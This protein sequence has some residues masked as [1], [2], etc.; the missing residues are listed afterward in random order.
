M[1]LSFRLIRLEL[2]HTWTI[3]RASVDFHDNIFVYLEHDGIAGIGEASFSRRYGESLESLQT[4][5]ESAKPVLANADPSHFAEIGEALQKLHPQQNSAKAALDMALMDWVGKKI[6]VPLFR[7]W[8]LN[9]VRTPVSS[10]TIGIDTPEMVQHKIREAQ[11][12][13][14]LKIKLGTARD[15]EIMRAVREATDKPLRIDAN[16]GWKSKE[17]ALEKICWLSQFNIEFVEQPMP[18]G[19]HEEMRWLRQ[20]L[21]QRRVP[22]P[23][24]A[25]EDSKTPR[26]LPALADVYD[27]INIK[28]M[29][30]G[31]LQQALRM[32]CL[33]RS[34]GLKIMLGCM[35]ESSVGITAAAHLAPL[36][37]Y[38]DLDGHL[39]ISN[40]P[41]VG[42]RM[43]NGG[44]TLPESPGL[45]VKER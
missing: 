15:E 38:A 37:D 9:P 16:E 22:M 36:A 21:Q 13:P 4:V 18:A 11:E 5:I 10:F 34:L 12:F 27:G 31:G 41:F 1:T 7:L 43:Q 40:D 26:D 39:L 20:K 8:G 29:K 17:E 42:V 45:G 30:S 2:K 23:L 28:L 19:R 14:I 35:I 25:D 6:G 44:T 32:I 3:S 24:F 33:A